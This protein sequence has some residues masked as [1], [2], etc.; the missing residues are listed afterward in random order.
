MAVDGAGIYAYDSSNKQTKL[1]LDTDGRSG[2][3]LNGNG[4]YT[5]CCDRFGDL[6]TGSYSGGVDLAIPM[7]HTLEY[8]T[9]EYLNNQSLIDNCVNDVFQSRDGKIW[10]AT[11]KGVSVYDAQTRLWHHGLYNKR[12]RLRFVRL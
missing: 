2:N 11:D 10:Y 4:L 5:L 8:I 7:K 9:H 12:W 6:W 3:V 1:L